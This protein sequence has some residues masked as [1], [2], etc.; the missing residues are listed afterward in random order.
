M[1]GRVVRAG[2]LVLQGK[3]EVGPQMGFSA[4]FRDTEGNC[5]GLQSPQ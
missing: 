4:L 1:L 5:V 3:T 2:G